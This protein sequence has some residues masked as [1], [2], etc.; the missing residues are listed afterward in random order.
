LALEEERERLATA[1]ADA[2]NALAIF[3]KERLGMSGG[4]QAGDQ[5]GGV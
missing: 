1:V 5:K 2:Q 3:E 4:E